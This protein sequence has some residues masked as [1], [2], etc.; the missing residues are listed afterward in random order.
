MNAFKAGHMNSDCCDQFPTPTTLIVSLA[1]A[2]SAAYPAAVQRHARRP[3]HVSM[4]LEPA[5][6]WQH[7]PTACASSQ[8]ALPGI[9]HA[10]PL[11]VTSAKRYRTRFASPVAPRPVVLSASSTGARLRCASAIWAFRVWG[12][13]LFH[14]SDRSGH[15]GGIG[16]G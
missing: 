14:S 15:A 9:S 16:R 1:V 12:R 8:L 7:T 2:A 6:Y 13:V 4:P 11:T 5:V 3:P 10:R